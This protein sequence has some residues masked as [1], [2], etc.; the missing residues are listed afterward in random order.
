MLMKK[1]KH[2]LRS[3]CSQLIIINEVEK[4]TYAS[5]PELL[6]KTFLTTQFQRLVGLRHI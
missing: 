1:A 2:K 3:A 6:M 4:T 5:S